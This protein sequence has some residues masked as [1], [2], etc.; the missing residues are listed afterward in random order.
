MNVKE[1]FLKPATD[2]KGYLRV[3]LA[4]QRKLTTKKVHRLVSEAFI[5]NALNKPTVN[6]INGI[7]TD[8][9]IENLEW[10]T[11][12]ENALHAVENGLFTYKTGCDHQRS[13]LTKEQI[14]RLVEMKNNKVINRIIAAEFNVSVSCVKRTFKREAIN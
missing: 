14:S 9:R 4:R 13:K 12:Q 10:N 1:R 3:G 7:K 8:N 11:Y 6:H 5:P 2:A